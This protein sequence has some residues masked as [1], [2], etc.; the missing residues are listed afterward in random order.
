MCTKYQRVLV[1]EIQAPV[2][3]NVTI[4]YQNERVDVF[5]GTFDS[6]NSGE[7]LYVEPAAFFGHSDKIL[8]VEMK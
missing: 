1:S 6:R 4:Y 8:R 5:L 2:S 7:F 3:R